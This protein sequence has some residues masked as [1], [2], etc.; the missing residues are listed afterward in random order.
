MGPCVFGSTKFK[1]KKIKILTI[2]MSRIIC[3]FDWE[4]GKSPIG[5]GVAHEEEAVASK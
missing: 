1:N 2:S 5:M 4:N 3:H